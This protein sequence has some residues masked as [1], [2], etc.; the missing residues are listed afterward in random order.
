MD[1][2]IRKWGNH[3]ALSLPALAL[4][5]AGL[6]LDQKVTI[7]V[8]PGRIVIEPSDQVEYKLE[9]LLAEITPQNVHAEIS[10]GKPVG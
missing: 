5:E 9:D 2:V 10:F 4:Q 3:P 8:S 7:F 6:R 1:A